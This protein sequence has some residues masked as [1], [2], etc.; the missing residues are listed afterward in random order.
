M[1]NQIAVFLMGVG[2]V[3]SSSSRAEESAAALAELSGKQGP[4]RFAKVRDGLYRGGQPTVRHLEL[5]HALG[6]QTIVNLRLGDRTARVEEAAAA[7]LGMRTV[8]VPFSGLFH[9]DPKFLLH[10]IDAIRDGGTVYVHCQ[11]GRD[12]TSLV[13]A[14]ER[15]LLEGWEA[16]KA[17]EHD[18]LTFGYRPVLF[19]AN[20]A[21]SFNAAVRRMAR[22]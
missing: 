4:E 20:I 8:H 21:D 3:V 18:A 19:H 12:R 1:P 5:L 15:V 7:K 16:A 22:R 9:V 6:V 17:W 14:L 2:L 11:L 13:I 10:A